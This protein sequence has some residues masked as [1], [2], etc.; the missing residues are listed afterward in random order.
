MSSIDEKMQQLGRQMPPLDKTRFV[1]DV[2]S[3]IEG[4]HDS[5]A[6]WSTIMRLAM[7]G[8]ALRATPAVFALIFGSLAGAALA[9]LNPLDE[10]DVFSSNAPYSVSALLNASGEVN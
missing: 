4:D 1:S 9:P 10:L 7:P 6:S 3:R 2:W 5:R 8:L